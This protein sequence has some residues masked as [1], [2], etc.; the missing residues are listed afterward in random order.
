MSNK[1]INEVRK[2]FKARTRMLPFAANFPGDRRFARTGWLC[3]CGEREEEQHIIE[4]RCPLYSDLLME[5][6]DLKE[7]EELVSFLNQVLDRRDLLA[8][9]DREEQEQR[10]QE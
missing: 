3:G 1:N 7:D 4:G 2:C 10:E 9:V 6:R 5:H 8:E